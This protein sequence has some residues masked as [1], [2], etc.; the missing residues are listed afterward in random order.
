MR[1]NA[2]GNHLAFRE[3]Q[4]Q[5]GA[6]PLGRTNPTMRFLVEKITLRP[7][8]NRGEIGATLHAELGTIGVHLAEITEAA[9]R[10]RSLQ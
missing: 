4:R 10:S 1:R 2:S 6:T 5:P 8:P 7:G 9:A 3:R